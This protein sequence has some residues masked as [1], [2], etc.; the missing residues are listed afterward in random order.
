[1]VR[2]IFETFTPSTPSLTGF[3]SNVTGGTWTLT[4]NSVPDG[5]AHQ[6]SLRNDSGTDHSGKTATFVGTDQDGASQ[7]ETIAMPGANATVETTLYFKTLTSVTPSA[8]IGTDTMDIGYVDEFSSRTIP[9]NWRGSQA[10][11]AVVVS[12]TINYSVQ[13]TPD[14]IQ[15]GC[16]AP[17]AS[18]PYNWLED[19][20]TSIVNSSTNG[21]E[22]FFV[23]PL[24]FRIIAN[25]YSAGASAKLTISQMN[26]QS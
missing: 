26:E 14:Y 5:L 11:V 17:P 7:T 21:S 13:Y 25:S 6:V 1:M 22:P 15:G 16:I 10:F 19:L 12:G 4:A 9:A 3:A 23:E 20:G 18:R 24:G 8:S 2:P